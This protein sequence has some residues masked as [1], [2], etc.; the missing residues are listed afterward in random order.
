MANSTFSQVNSS[1]GQQLLIN[2]DQIRYIRT[3]ATQTTVFIYFYDIVQPL[4]LAA[5]EGALFLADIRS[6]LTEASQ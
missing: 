6:N 1:D 5:P 3:D 4:K 2:L